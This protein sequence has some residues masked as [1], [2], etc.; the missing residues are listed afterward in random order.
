MRSDVGA[1]HFRQAQAREAGSWP[2]K[3]PRGTRRCDS[4]CALFTGHPRSE[5]LDAWMSSSCF[6]EVLEK[7]IISMRPPWRLVLQRI[8]DHRY[9]KR[10]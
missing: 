8:A 6:L 7:S 5:A 9:P 10:G 2:S 3:H 1:A 4:I